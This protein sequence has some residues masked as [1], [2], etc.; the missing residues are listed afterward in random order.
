MQQYTLKKSDFKEFV[1]KVMEKNDFIAPVTGNPQKTPAKSIFKKISDPKEIFLDKNSYFP[2]KSFFF[3]P[4]ETLFKFDGNKI[5]DPKIN[6]KQKVFFGVRK[7]DLNGV[8]H[9]DIVFRRRLFII[10]IYSY[11]GMLNY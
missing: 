8:M 3:D 7:C 4:K 6:I 2:V 10:N 1:A 5:I 9:Q 11:I